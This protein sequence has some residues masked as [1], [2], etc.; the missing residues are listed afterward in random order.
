MIDLILKPLNLECY[1]YDTYTDSIILNI[2]SKDCK[3]KMTKE[4]L[5]ISS[6]LDNNDI[7]YIIDDMSNIGIYYSN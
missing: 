6:T 3:S 4:M 7:T 5:N 1:E 2:K